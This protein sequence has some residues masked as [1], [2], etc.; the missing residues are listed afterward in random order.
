LL[1]V[2]TFLLVLSLASAPASSAQANAPKDLR[3]D[4]AQIALGYALDQICDVTQNTEKL[5]FM[6]D[7]INAHWWMWRARTGVNKPIAKKMTEKAW[8]MTVGGTKCSA[9]SVLQIKEAR[10]VLQDFP[11][12]AEAL[13]GTPSA[14]LLNPKP[15]QKRIFAT[16]QAARI[17][18]V[19]SKKCNEDQAASHK[20]YVRLMGARKS[21]LDV[22]RPDQLAGLEKS[23]A[24]MQLNGMLG[25]CSAKR[26]T[27]VRLAM[28]E[29]MGLLPVNGEPAE[30]AVGSDKTKTNS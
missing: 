10:S 18:W 2:A 14:S 30:Q 24:E 8:K 11:I 26:D 13:F 22:F 29:L 19:I 6:A 12:N 20:I 7:Y 1:R 3:A 27:F 15:D 23:T 17:A 21:L 5:A 4:F 9:T 28:D 25:N 16:Y